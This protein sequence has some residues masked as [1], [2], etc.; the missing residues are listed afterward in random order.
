MA[1]ARATNPLVEQF[2]RGGVPQDLR[3]MAAQGAAPAQARRPRRAAA[4]PA[5]RRRG[6]PGGGR[7]ALAS[8]PERAAPDLKDRETPR[9]VLAWAIDQPARE[10]AA[11]GRAP[12]PSAARRDIEAACR[13]ACPT[14]WPSWSSS[15]RRACC[16][17][18]R[19]S[20]R[21]KATRT[22]ATTSSAAC[23]SCA[24]R[25]TSGEEAR[26]PRAACARPPPE[27]SAAPEAEVRRSATSRS[28][29]TRRSSRY[30]T[31][32]EQQETEKVSAVQRSTA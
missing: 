14:S 20:R 4:P 28:P 3:L 15:T 29:R 13:R 27:P 7:E 19:C 31:D 12:E 9:A 26:H 2:R 30:L 17:A 8:F 24:R 18:P 10:G 22:W 6:R 1:E 21:S 25:S 16:A 32:E 5:R 23:A 11:R